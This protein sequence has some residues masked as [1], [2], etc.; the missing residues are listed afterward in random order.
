MSSSL[1]ADNRAIAAYVA[2]AEK[3]DGVPLPADLLRQRAIHTNPK[4]KR[5]A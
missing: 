5:A 4:L 2:V 1:S 3:L